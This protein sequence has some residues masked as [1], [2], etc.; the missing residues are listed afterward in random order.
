MPSHSPLADVTAMPIA[1][2]VCFLVEVEDD[3]RGRGRAHRAARRGRVKVVI[4][5]MARGDAQAHR[6]FVTGD[7]RRE[8]SRTRHVRLPRR[9]QRRGDDDGARVQRRV[10]VHVVDLV[11]GGDGAGTERSRFGIER[12]RRMC[13]TPKV[14]AQHRRRCRCVRRASPRADGRPGRGARALRRP[15]AAARLRSRGK[16]RPIRGRWSRRP[17]VHG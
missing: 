4:V 2:A 16:T 12:E 11:D 10:L 15:R 1:C 3:G 5:A 6:D 9:R 7:D 17:R 8:Q 14:A 13:P